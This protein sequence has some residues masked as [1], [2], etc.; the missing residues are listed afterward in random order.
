MAPSLQERKQYWLK[1]SQLCIVRDKRHWNYN[2]GA[3]PS[4][5]HAV[6]LCSIRRRMEKGGRGKPCTSNA[7]VLEEGEGT[8][9]RLWGVEH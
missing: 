5:L 7:W 4:N 6:F 8:D 2:S 3:L 1:K 9:M